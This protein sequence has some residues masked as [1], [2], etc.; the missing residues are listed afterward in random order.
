MQTRLSCAI[1]SGFGC[2]KIALHLTQTQVAIQNVVH[3]QAFE[4]IYLLTHVGNTPIG[5]QQAIAVVGGQFTPK[6]R[7]QAGFAG[8]ISA[9]QAGFLAGVQGQLG[10]F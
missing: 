1:V 10:V 9:D 6:Q 3:R 4:G 5:R 8:A 2:R 7:E